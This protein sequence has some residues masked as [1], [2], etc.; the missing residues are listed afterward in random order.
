MI[1]LINKK[2]SSNRSKIGIEGIENLCK[3]LGLN[4]Y[5]INTGVSRLFF[6]KY[7]N[8]I[9]KLEGNQFIVEQVIEAINNL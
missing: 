4:Y 9:I 6:E 8:Y 3:N 2:I 5:I 1:K 7:D